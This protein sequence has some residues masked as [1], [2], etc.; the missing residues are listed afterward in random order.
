[1]VGSGAHQCVTAYSFLV[2]LYNG[3][4]GSPIESNFFF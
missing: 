1:M 4:L 2:I 3:H